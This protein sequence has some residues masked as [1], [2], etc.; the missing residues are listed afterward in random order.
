MVEVLSWG[1]GR[2]L[3]YDI[4]LILQGNTV[5]FRILQFERHYM[6]KDAAKFDAHHGIL[7][8]DKIE[9]LKI[10]SAQQNTLKKK[11]VK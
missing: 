2:V 3:T 6:Q 8:K 11:K 9:E 5:S 7:H 10:L 1:L 4:M